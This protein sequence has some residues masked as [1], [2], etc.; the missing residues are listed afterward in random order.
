M[1]IFSVAA[2][3]IAAVTATVA[4]EKNSKVVNVVILVDIDYPRFVVPISDHYKHF[5]LTNI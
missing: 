3:A 5:I 1:S 2:S 4:I